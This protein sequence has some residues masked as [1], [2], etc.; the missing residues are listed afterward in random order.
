M[1]S[2]TSGPVNGRTRSSSPS[3]GKHRVV[4]IALEDGADLPCPRSTICQKLF[5]RQDSLLRHVRTHTSSD[6]GG[7]AAPSP[8]PQQPQLPVPTPTHHV[9][10]PQLPHDYPLL[11][12]P[13]IAAPQLTPDN[14]YAQYLPPPPHHASNPAHT[15][16]NLFVEAAG[17][18]Q[19]SEARMEMED[20]SL[21]SDVWSPD[22]FS[23][24]AQTPF[25]SFLDG[26]TNQLSPSDP[27]ALLNLFTHGD[28]PFAEHWMLDLANPMPNSDWSVS[29]PQVASRIASRAGSPVPR[30]TPLADSPLSEIDRNHAIRETY[31]L[32]TDAVSLTSLRVF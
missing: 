28:L 16:I 24:Y 7:G 29:L 10:I 12:A 25:P 9:P 21:E 2:G 19:E 18:L 5:A 27:D 17:M 14:P 13:H 23:D 26:S 22:F 1:L 6:A 31:S 3:H 11:A 30:E 8:S 32:I 15:A 20:S 4:N